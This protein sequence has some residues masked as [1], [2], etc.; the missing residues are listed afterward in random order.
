MPAQVSRLH[1]IIKRVIMLLLVLACLIPSPVFG[2][3]TFVIRKPVWAGRFYPGDSQELRRGIEQLVDQ[4]RRLK[5]ENKQGPAMGAGQLRA[6][7]FPHAGYEYSGIVAA[8]SA[9]ELE[10]RRFSTVILMGP[11]HRAGLI[12]VALTDM[13]A[14]ET[15][16]GIIKISEKAA[17]LRSRDQLFKPVPLS[18]R[19]EHSLEVVLP[20][21][22]YTLKQFELIPLV[23][24]PCD[25]D[26]ISRA[27]SPLVNDDTLVAVSSDL[28]H[29]MPCDAA[30]R[31]DAETIDMILR[32]DG[33][34]LLSSENRACGMYPLA[35]LLKLA[36][37][38]DWKPGL[39][40]YRN[41]GDTTGDC[42]RVVGYG[43]IAFYQDDAAVKEE[44][45]RDG[46]CFISLSQGQALVKL[47]RITVENAFT[48][49]NEKEVLPS[50]LDAPELR[51]HRGTFVTITKHGA[52]RGCIGNIIPRDSIIESV[53]RNAL[54]AAFHDY[55]FSPLR[56]DELRDIR[57]EVSILTLPERLDYHGADDLISKLKP[58]VHGVIIGTG[59]ASATFLPQVWK[60]LPEPEEF[61]SR[62]CR[63]AG[64]PMDA[65]RRNNLQVQTY[66]VQYF[67]EEPA[68]V[69]EGSITR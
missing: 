56:K 42:S 48:G 33:S 25:P 3:D 68:H 40:L 32:L 12:N 35:V 44:M 8:R 15:P 28:S 21:L 36:K 58:G 29:Y 53:R 30:R 59:R 41:S 43:A 10:G 4:A 18:D 46:A 16:L 22:Q 63:K 60:Q 23:V 24:G 66:Q 47:A 64:L 5:E 62:L 34:A 19:T 14:Y 26:R 6:L 13:S 1:I 31:R 65:W 11:D 57:F 50:A 9:L 38:Y 52:L 45:K 54:N 49:K 55:R 17:V 2:K 51:E 7:V 27:I 69:Q 20:F 39:L 61:L 37:Q 67:D